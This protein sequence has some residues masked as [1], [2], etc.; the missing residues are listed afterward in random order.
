EVIPAQACG[1][2]AVHQLERHAQRERRAAAISHRDELDGLV[3]IEVIVIRERLGYEVVTGVGDEDREIVGNLVVRLG[4]A[5]FEV[6]G[7]PGETNEGRVARGK[8]EVLEDVAAAEVLEGAVG[9]A[10]RGG[11][12]TPC[13]GPGT[14]RAIAGGTGIKDA[15]GRYLVHG[16]ADDA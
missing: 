10:N 13:V 7:V 9:A 15:A 14:V 11:G 16:L 12:G 6:G 5:A 1:R 2:G 3:G 8:R 4:G